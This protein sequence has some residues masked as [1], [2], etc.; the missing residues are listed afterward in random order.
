[1]QEMTTTREIKRPAKSTGADDLVTKEKAFTGA[2]VKGDH[3]RA[4]IVVSELLSSQQTLG[5]IYTQVI[6][7]ALV[8]VGELWCRDDIGVGEEHLASEIV[9]GQMDR[10]RGLFAKRDSRSPYRIM[11]GCI[12][13]ELHYIGARMNADLC[14]AQGWNVDFIGANVPNN[15]LIEVVNNRQPQILALSITMEQ[16]LAKADSALETLERT[17]PLLSIVIGGQAIQANDANAR[18]GSRCQIARDAVEGV[19]IIGRLL[20]LFRPGAVLKE[21]QLVLAR[22]V[23]DLRTRKG[24]TQEQLADATSVTRVCIVA[25]E[26]GKQNVSMDILVRLANALGVAPESLLSAQG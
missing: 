21:Y 18:W 17:A 22:R 13:G 25:V 26:G 16:G 11:I 5:D 10:L 8:T 24:W 20:R 3:D 19:A 9:L 2:I 6:S 4:E 12:E 23:R 15:A 14:L 7:P 1:M